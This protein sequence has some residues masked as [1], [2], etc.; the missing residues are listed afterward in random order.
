MKFLNTKGGSVLRM[1]IVAA[2][3]AM[4]A[5]AQASSL[6]AGQEIII[7]GLGGDT[8]SSVT[9]SSVLNSVTTT[10]FPGLTSYV[11]DSSFVTSVATVHYNPFIAESLWTS[12]NGISFAT[13]SETS[14]T[15]GQAGVVADGMGAFTGSYGTVA[16]TWSVAYTQG[17]YTDTFKVAS[18]PLP[19]ALFFVAPALAGVFGFSRRK[20]GAKLAA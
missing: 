4:G 14:Y 2:L 18:T 17:G 5:N 6:T 9:S 13:T 12:S 7:N 11:P 10:T 1:S 3:F 16:G 20:N 19:A 8:G 15:T